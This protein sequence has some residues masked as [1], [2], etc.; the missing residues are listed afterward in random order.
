MM[1]HVHGVD[2]AGEDRWPGG[3]YLVDFDGRREYHLS[4]LWANW[5]KMTTFRTD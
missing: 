3:G 4:S 5:M 1:V 2:G